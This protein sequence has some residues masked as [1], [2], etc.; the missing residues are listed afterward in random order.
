MNSILETPFLIWLYTLK[1]FFSHTLLLGK[2]LQIN[3]FDLVSVLNHI[4]D[5]PVQLQDVWN[6]SQETFYDI[7]ELVSRKKNPL[8]MELE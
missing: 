6:K 1:L 5:I 4:S 7:Y 3:E 8:E 2:A